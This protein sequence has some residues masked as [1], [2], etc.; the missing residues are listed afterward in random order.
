MHGR[1]SLAG[2][3]R[4]RGDWGHYNGAVLN[5]SEEKCQLERMLSD[6]MAWAAH[7]LERRPSGAGTRERAYVEHDDPMQGS[8]TSSSAVARWSFRS[9]VPILDPFDDLGGVSLVSAGLLCLQQP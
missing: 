9:Y 1:G 5:N 2:M 7:R 3:H 4:R 8:Y 6:A